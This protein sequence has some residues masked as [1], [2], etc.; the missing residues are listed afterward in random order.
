MMQFFDDLLDMFVMLLARWNIHRL[1]GYEKSEERDT[2][3][4]P[5]LVSRKDARCPGCVASE[6]QD[7]ITDHL[8]LNDLYCKITKRS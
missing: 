5:E 4:F 1:Y 2:V 7:W 8:T 3:D 6:I